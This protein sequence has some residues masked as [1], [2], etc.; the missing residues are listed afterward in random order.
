LAGFLGGLALALFFG[1]AATHVLTGDLPRPA[2]R[3]P[4]GGR[5][6]VRWLALI[7]GMAS[8]FA[9][10]LIASGFGIRLFVI[11]SHRMG[12]PAILESEGPCRLVQDAPGLW[13][14]RMDL[15]EGRTPG[16]SWPCDA[17]HSSVASCCLFFR[18]DEA[19]AGTV[20]HLTSPDETLVVRWLDLPFAAGGPTLLDVRPPLREIVAGDTTVEVWR[21]A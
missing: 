3:L 18:L 14:L 13:G 6:E 21:A 17:G 9:S 19:A 5:D 4:W 11:L 15:S 10:V 20:S 16:P 12:W 2:T 1:A 7:L 8:C